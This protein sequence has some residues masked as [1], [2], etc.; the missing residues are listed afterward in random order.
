MYT[1]IYIYMYIYI[2][3]NIAVYACTDVYMYM[4]TYIIQMIYLSENIKN[5]SE[6]TIIFI[7]NVKSMSAH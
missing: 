3:T 7:T 6:H 1:H 5:T 4:Y 2:Y